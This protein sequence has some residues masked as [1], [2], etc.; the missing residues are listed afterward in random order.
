MGQKIEKVKTHLRENKKTYIASSCTAVVAIVSTLLVM[1]RRGGLTVGDQDINQLGL[2]NWK[3]IAKN[4]FDVDVAYHIEPLGDPG[5][6][7][8]DETT[9]GVFASQGATARALDVHPTR[10]SDHLH[11]KTDHVAGHKLKIIGKA[12]DI[13]L[14]NTSR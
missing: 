9:G 8:L 13:D 6:V 3:P 11:G 7:I 2:V 5:N 14:V 4:I 10:V 12:G 1:N